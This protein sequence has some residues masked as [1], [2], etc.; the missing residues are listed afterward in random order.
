MRHAVE[1]AH[2]RDVEEDDGQALGGA[3]RGVRAHVTRTGQLKQDQKHCTWDYIPE[4]RPANQRNYSTAAL[5][6]MQVDFLTWGTMRT[7]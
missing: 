4:L 3:Q 5:L 1:P 6:I 2:G 7:A